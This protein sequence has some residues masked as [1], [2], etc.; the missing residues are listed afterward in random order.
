MVVEGGAVGLAIRDA[1]TAVLR[2]DDAVERRARV[3]LPDGR[4]ETLA[5]WKTVRPISD[6]SCA[7][8]RAVAWRSIVLFYA[9]LV[10]P[11]WIR[12]SGLS[13]PVG[14][15]DPAMLALVDWGSERVCIEALRV[16]TGDGAWTIARFDAGGAGRVRFAEG[17]E[18][19]QRLEC[20][21][22]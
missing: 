22:R 1:D 10:A 14:G 8:A 9:Y 19:R 2:V 12:V 16:R 11:P 13:A 4:T 5:A 15:I 17:V 7:S 18:E 3:T 21:L 6:A 20:T